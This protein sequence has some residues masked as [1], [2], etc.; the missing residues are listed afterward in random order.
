VKSVNLVR[1]LNQN[2]R[3]RGL[4][5]EVLKMTVSRAAYLH[6]LLSQL[7]QPEFFALK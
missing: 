1:Q 4:F 5:L 6:F 7:A 2:L 3:R